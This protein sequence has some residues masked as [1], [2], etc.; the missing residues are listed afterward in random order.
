M[1]RA[2]I[3]QGEKCDLIRIE[4]ERV[5]ESDSPQG[6]EGWGQAED[7]GSAGPV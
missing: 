3:T 7:G 1:C 6:W 5:Q 4:M 2:I